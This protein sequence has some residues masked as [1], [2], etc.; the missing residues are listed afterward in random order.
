MTNHADST[1]V[2]GFAVSAP[3]EAVDS[4]E[5]KMRRFLRWMEEQG[6]TFP[7]M[8]MKVGQGTRQVHATR[9]LVAGE[10][11]L[12]VPRKLMITPE[13]AK[14]SEAG[15]LIAQH[16]C[17]FGDYEYI[18]AYLLQIKREGG[19]WKPYVDVLPKDYAENAL[20]FSESEL[21]YL[22]GSYISERIRERIEWNARLHDRL[23]PSLKENGF[24]PEAFAWARCAVTSRVYGVTFGGC[25][26]VAMVPLAD[27]FDHA[28]RNYVRWI[29]E[30]EA[31]FIVTA[32]QPV[33]AGAPLFERY[34]KRCNAMLLNVYGFC[35]EDNPDNEAEILLQPVSSDHLFFRPAQKLGT[36]Q[37]EMQAFRVQRSYNDAARALFSYLR[38]ACLD[39]SPRLEG[40]GVDVNKADNVPPVSRKNEVAA[41][42]A[43]VA[44]CESRLRQFRT[45]AE[46]DETLLQDPALPRNVRNIVMVRRD[47]K[48]IVKHFLELA[49][50]AL[51][52]LRDA[53]CDVGEH[54]VGG[55]PY[56]D[57][58][59]DVVRVLGNSAV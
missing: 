16:G 29:A 36:K 18:A 4:D 9:P 38:L 43:L 26:T 49:Q 5:L 20:F 24:T 37:R 56:A 31:G 52:L 1:V 42:T 13:I 32:Q 50:T 34:G 30:A 51:P 6:A 33:A 54:A 2:D 14:A 57:Y 17:D 44:A 45:S 41:L 3:S 8:T 35:L 11:V 25:K 10:L 55:K 22:H 21:G 53:S 59:S 47:E 7:A 23:P 27:M 48:A 40:S 15:K 46:E 19:F 28:P 39:E 12:H 58:F